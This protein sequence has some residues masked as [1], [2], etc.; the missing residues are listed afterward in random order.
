[1]MKL[2]HLC[3]SACLFGALYFAYICGAR[4]IGG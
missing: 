3:V 4:L 2:E 1:M